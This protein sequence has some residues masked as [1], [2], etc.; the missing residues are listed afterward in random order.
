MGDFIL[1]S[2]FRL[3]FP[4]QRELLQGDR[5]GKDQSSQLQS[6]LTPKRA[7]VGLAFLVAL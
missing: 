7:E 1:V 5:I 4:L 3:L 2:G 6:L